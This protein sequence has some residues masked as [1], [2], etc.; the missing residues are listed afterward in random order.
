MGRGCH[1]NE[2]NDIQHDGLFA[3]LSINNTEQNDAKRNS[4]MF[5][6]AE[7]RDFL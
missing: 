3:T 4:N 7:C 2:Q 1:D 5:H 6:Y